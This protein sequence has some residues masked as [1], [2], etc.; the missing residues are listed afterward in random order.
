MWIFTPIYAELDSIQA[1]NEFIISLSIHTTCHQLFS[2]MNV[3]QK[4]S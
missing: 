4:L 3:A 1:K 2:S